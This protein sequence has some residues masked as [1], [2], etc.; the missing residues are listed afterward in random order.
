MNNSSLQQKLELA[1]HELLD[2]GLRGNPLL[3]V[4][5]NK[6]FLDIV[7]EQSTEVANILVEEKKAMR[8]LPL[9]EAY[10]KD[11]SGSDDELAAEQDEEQESL[12]PLEAYL[13]QE[14]G[15]ERFSDLYL[16]TR[17]PARELD[18]RLIK[19]EN[20]A[21]TLLQE[22]GIEVLYLALGFLEWYEDENAHTPRYA[23]LI[24]LPVELQRES[25]RAGFTLSF[26]NAEMGG[27]L[28]LAARLK[29]DFRLTL[30]EFDEETSLVDYFG[31]VQQM[32]ADR[33]RWEVHVDQIRLGL[34]SFGKFQMYTD[35]DPNNWPDSH[36]LLEHPQLEKLFET[37][38]REDAER[39][40]AS[41]GHDLLKTPES[42]HL[43]KDADSSQLEAILAV[44]EGASLV[45]QGPPG[46]GKSQTISNLIG[47]ALARGK[48]V[49]F[50]AQKM[51]ALDVVK[52]RLD[53]C[54]LGDAVLELH[55]HKSNKKAVL[56]SLRRVFDNGRPKVPD[57]SSAYQR[58]GEVRESLDGYVEEIRAPILAS[59][60]DYVTALGKML[61]LQRD[62]RLQALQRIDFERLRHWGPQELA[63]GQRAM[64]AMGDYLAEYGPPS[65]NSYRNSRR[66]DLSPGEEQ[67]LRKRVQQAADQL[68]E[69]NDNAVSLAQAMQLPIPQDFDDIAIL[70]RAGKRALNAPHL[71]GVKVNTE[72]WQARRDEVHQAIA[73]GQALSR[74]HDAMQPRFIEAVYD[75]DMLPIRT[76]LAGRAD[77]WWRIFS[78]EY[79]RAASTLKG[80]A[81]GQL[82]G[83][84]VDWL[85]WVDELLEAQQHRKTLERLSPTCQT[86]FGAQW[87]GE[88]SDW[89]VLAQLAEWIIDLYEAIGKG[90]LPA[91][92]AAFL[93]GNPDLREYTD[94]VEALQSHSERVRGMLQDLCR[95][96]E[97]G[98]EVSALTLDTWHQRL[99]GWRDTAQLYAV[100]RFNQ[101]SEDLEK[102]ELGHLTAT[103]A[104]WSH[105]PRALSAWLELSYF[106]GLV[107]H[108]YVERPRLAR[109][110]RLTHE[111][112]IQEF[113]QLDGASF[114]YAQESLVKRLHAN[115]PSKYAPGE[116]DI[117]RREFTKKRRHLPI[118]KLLRE[119]GAV[120]QQAKPVFMMSPMSVAGYLAQGN[121]DFDLVI[122]DEASQIPA[123]EALGAI[124]RGRQV[125][126]V[127]DSKQMPPTNFFGQSV[128]LSDE[129]AEESA[130]AD[131]ESILGMM[132]AQG[133]PERMLRWHYRSRHHSLI[134]VSNDQFYDN[135]LLIFPSP[136]VHPEAR[137]L[138][139]RHLPETHYDRGG[140]RTNAGE[141]RAVAEAVI[142]HA[143][144]SPQLSLGVVAFSTA[145]REAILLEVE[146]LRREHEELEHF[147]RHHDGGD[148]F[149]IKNLEN[150]QG[151]ERDV[152]F[153]SVGYGRTSAGRLGQNFGPINKTGGERRLNVLISRARLAMDVFANFQA[154]ELKVT[155]SSPFGVRALQAFLKYAETGELPTHE[156]TDR[157]PDSPF[158]W[159]VMRAI[160]D[161]GYEVQPQ[162]GS[163]G[164]FIDL[165][166]RD[167]E[168][169]G[170]FLLAVECDGASYHS[171]AVARDRD[172]LRQSV[173]EGLGW[174]FHRIWSTE[175]FRN[176]AAETQ[177]LKEAIEAAQ[178]HQKALEATSPGSEE[179]DS[180]E[181][182]QDAPGLPVDTDDEA[183][184]PPPLSAA[185]EREAA[186]QAAPSIP[187]YVPANTDTLGL[188]PAD[189]QFEEIPRDRLQQAIHRVVAHE[190]PMHIK[191]LLSRL[192]DA[193]GL[194]RAG[195]RIQRR[196]EA[197]SQSLERQGRLQRQGDF[198]STPER[199]VPPRRDWSSLPASERKF[200][201][202]PPGELE[203]ALM[204]T[205]KDSVSI[206][207][208]DA[209]GAAI[210][211]LGF[212]RLTKPIRQRVETVLHELHDRGE[213][214]E[215]NGRLQLTDPTAHA[216][217]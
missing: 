129:E 196:V 161:L 47:E 11:E 116:M 60:T 217:A 67:E 24:L 5:S 80:Y 107:D 109:F 210:N 18:T 93:D 170:R 134:A 119:A 54:H 145:Q 27:N 125:V 206:E 136:G 48:K 207:P 66:H 75:A 124:L 122:F 50:V 160:Q 44:M 159:E 198:L 28:A 131:V 199:T 150:V 34:F 88:E 7:D 8:F 192:T 208:V 121:L 102:A 23:P 158:E 120:I 37:G 99:A 183:A 143:R 32:I 35:L 189:S 46:T 4:P 204:L 98:E 113:N 179:D 13:E 42:L 58:L 157:E 90:E 144:Q 29:Q 9:P 171:S 85:G 169:P 187:A 126:V 133:M 110:D 176:A 31:Q 1:R 211:L 51:A 52:S 25:A 181:S 165:A 49:L 118:R 92:L 87:Q 163:Q 123:P 30:P 45:V 76:G 105:A 155:E 153:I 193:T 215:R 59:Q 180:G 212:K 39:L 55:S 197:E 74:T 201:L 38:Y 108:A 94:Q 191:M 71:A 89:S 22:Q 149:F 12:P 104:N 65:E 127:G 68:T 62:E 140:S 17:L 117:L 26:T 186:S 19:L 101:L 213:V 195:A 216:N 182:P 138:H 33:P 112:L 147:F 151:D 173:L 115:L 86:L 148:E 40:E 154:D 57:R 96:I 130:T 20:E 61:Q 172:R 111:R 77:K 3:H 146:R 21:H 81:R 10:E 142:Q 16:Q 53:E 190:G 177:R 166:I 114:Q 214:Q 64:D 84:P 95:Q 103:L 43:V 156:M 83:T 14:Q 36:Q 91:G 79:R 2:M 69:M 6:R 205:L 132:K 202:V 100:V 167:P 203:Q 139:F 178:R 200:E 56:D 106:G 63:R 185:I 97:W 15:E 184:E 73:A 162:V 188:S 41:S 135:Q 209:M 175:W 164:F 72:Q 128:E 137:G 78:G 168:A 82:T 152:I 141:A 194:Q 70:Q 174:R